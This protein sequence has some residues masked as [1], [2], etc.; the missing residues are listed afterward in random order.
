MVFYHFYYYSVD[1]FFILSFGFVFFFFL[2]PT[3]N[4]ILEGKK[5][6]EERSSIGLEWKIKNVHKG[7]QINGCQSQ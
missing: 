5:Y 1:Y 6:F 3:Y 2:S 7:N 4:N